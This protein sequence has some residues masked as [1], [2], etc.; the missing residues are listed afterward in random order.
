[1]NLQIRPIGPDDTA[2]ARSLLL[3]NGLLIDGIDYSAWTPP[4]LVALKEGQVVGLV[5]ALAGL[6]YAVITELAVARQFHGKG[7]GVKLMEH[8]ETVLRLL[9]CQGW[10]A[11]E[12]HDR[13]DMQEMIERWGGQRTGEGVGYLRRFTYV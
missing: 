12:R 9:G 7:Y 13:Y 1:M 3:E 10:L 11:F 4:T 6:P 8:L 5:Q 2:A